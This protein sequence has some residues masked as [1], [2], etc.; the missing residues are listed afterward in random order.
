MYWWCQREDKLLFFMIDMH[1]TDISSCFTGFSNI[2]QVLFYRIIISDKK[3][4]IFCGWLVDLI[5]L[6]K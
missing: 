3:N 2:T 4:I 1:Y 5:P 6:Q